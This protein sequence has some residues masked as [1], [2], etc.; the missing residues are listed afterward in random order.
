M[1]GL[2][3]MRAR[4][5]TRPVARPHDGAGGVEALPEEGEDDDGQ[6]GGG[7]DG[8]GE[9][10]EE[11]DVRRGAEEDGEADGDE[12]DDEGGDAGDEDFL[13]GL[14]LGAVVDDV[15]IEIVREGGGGADGQARR[16]RRGWWRRRWR[17]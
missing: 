7:G 13:A 16:R 5:A 17:R 4:E 12:A 2:M 6:I 9:A 11:G 8:E 1:L 10:D 14:P 3:A 15:R